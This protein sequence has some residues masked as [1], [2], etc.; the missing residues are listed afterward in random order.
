MK[1]DY[2]PPQAKT[3]TACETDGAEKTVT[4][5][6]V[7]S[8]T[9][10]LLKPAPLATVVGFG[11]AAL[12]GT[13]DLHGLWSLAAAAATGVAA[14]YGARWGRKLGFILGFL[15]GGA[16]GLLTGAAVGAAAG[17]SAEERLLASLVGGGVAATAGATL[18]TI[19]G[20]ITGYVGGGVLV[21]NLAKA[22]IN[23]WARRQQTNASLS[24]VVP[25]RPSRESALRPIANLAIQ[26]SF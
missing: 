3:P 10:S 20:A 26:K 25:Q 13:P 21:Y 2:I 12:F 17:K 8:K 11:V 18:F 16:A 6:P 15:G 22:D 7:R 24:E 4:P 9:S 19:A 5:P 1:I 23:D 14:G